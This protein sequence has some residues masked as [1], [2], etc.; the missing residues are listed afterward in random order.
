MTSCDFGKMAG[1]R[2][3]KIN[4]KLYWVG[5]VISCQ[6]T[7][8]LCKVPVPSLV[9]RVTLNLLSITSIVNSVAH[10]C[11]LPPPSS[12]LSMA[13]TE[14]VTSAIHP[15]VRQYNRIIWSINNT[16]LEVMLVIKRSSCVTTHTH[17]QFL[18]PC[19]SYIYCDSRSLCAN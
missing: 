17:S 15:I 1:P 14:T 2:E 5:D 10:T 9:D 18:A 8:I 7:F 6:E 3:L 16:T 4:F 12:A 11:T 19:S 13:G